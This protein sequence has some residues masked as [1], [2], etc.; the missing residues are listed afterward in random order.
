MFKPC[1]AA[2]SLI[3]AAGPTR[4]ALMI[5]ASAESTAPRN[6]LSPQGCT[7]TVD[8]VGT[9]FAAAIRRSYFDPGCGPLA[10]AGM[11]LMVLL[12]MTA[13]GPVLVSTP[14]RRKPQSP[15]CVRSRERI[16]RRLQHR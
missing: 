12:R 4:I 5:P 7:T 3:L 13:K 10:L 1:L 6:Q 9:P 16:L 14:D 11:A 2:T 8:T 15:R